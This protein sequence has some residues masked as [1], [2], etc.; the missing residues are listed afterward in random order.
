ML[1]ELAISGKATDIV[2]ADNDLLSLPTGHGDA[3][4]RLRQRLPNLRIV[5]P[6]EFL[7]MHHAALEER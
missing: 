6:S 2:S 3:S 5:S 7:G 4:K 1:I